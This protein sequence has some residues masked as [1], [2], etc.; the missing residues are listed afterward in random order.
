MTIWHLINNFSLFNQLFNHTAIAGKANLT[1]DST[2][3]YACPK[4]NQQK[5]LGQ[6]QYLFNKCITSHVI[7]LKQYSLEYFIINSSLQKQLY[8]TRVYMG[9]KQLVI[10]TTCET[11]IKCNGIN[12][13][14]FC[15]ICTSLFLNKYV[16]FNTYKAD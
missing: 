11:E 15:I 4:Q 5:C 3:S 7:I 2:S 12:P 14:V 8:Y 10:S 13:V 6:Q 16:N 9:E 1:L